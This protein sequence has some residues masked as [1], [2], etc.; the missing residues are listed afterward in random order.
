MSV[1][2]VIAV[3]LLRNSLVAIEAGRP[4]NPTRNAEPPPRGA[5]GSLIWADEFDGPR[6]RR[7]YPRKWRFETGYG[8]GDR[9]LQA[10]TARRSNASVDGWGC[11]A[12][13]ARKA[14]DVPS[15]GDTTSHTSARLNTRDRFEFA[16]GLLEARMCRPV[17]DRS[18]R[19]DWRWA[20]ARFTV[21]GHLHREVDR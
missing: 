2:P 16:Y 19:G 15:D 5:A 10:Y 7:P 20:V 1:A 13:T 6:G 21:V 14:A 4:S 18:A 17:D 9:E 8:W 3:L 12:I 11:L